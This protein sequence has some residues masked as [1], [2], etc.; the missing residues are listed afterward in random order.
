MAREFYLL[1]RNR[2][3]VRRSGTAPQSLCETC[4]TECSKQQHNE[5]Q[6]PPTRAVATPLIG[7]IHEG[8][9]LT[10]PARTD[11]LLGGTGHRS[12]DQPANQRFQRSADA[13][14]LQERRISATAA[15]PPDRPF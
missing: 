3:F 4:L 5:E 12:E 11:L 1:K 7:L 14:P 6:S 9:L 8:T 10:L 15:Q 2:V 13:P